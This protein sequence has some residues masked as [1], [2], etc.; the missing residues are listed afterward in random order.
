MTRQIYKGIKAHDGTILVSHYRHDYKTYTDKE[1]RF[2][3]IDGG[4]EDY[5]RYSWP[6]PEEKPNWV[7][8]V[9]DE[10]NKYVE[11]KDRYE[12]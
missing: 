1:G 9:L 6:I 7:E 10:N 2:Y 11:T 4:Q 12:L 3:M 5:V 8:V